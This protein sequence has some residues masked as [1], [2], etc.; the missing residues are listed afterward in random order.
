M[1]VKVGLPRER[2]W[3]RVTQLKHNGTILATVDNDLIYTTKPQCG[4]E[5]VLQPRNIL[6]TAD[7]S[8]LICFLVLTQ[9]STLG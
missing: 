1:W 3:C 8:D 7:T 4:D 2:F 9:R 5:V 6:E